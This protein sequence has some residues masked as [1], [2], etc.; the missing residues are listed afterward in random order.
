MC[1][2]IPREVLSVDL[3]SATV[4]TET[5]TVQVSL[6]LMSEPVE[7]GDWVTVQ[8]NRYAIGR[9]DATEAQVRLDL[10]AELLDFA[11][12][13]IELDH[14][15]IWIT[16]EG[17]VKDHVPMGAKLQDLHLPILDQVSANLL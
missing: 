3:F 7:V 8:A 2:A 14:I 11:G 5:E 12:L 16:L 6:A 17:T 15:A 9:M 13:H 4:A 1:I 10:F